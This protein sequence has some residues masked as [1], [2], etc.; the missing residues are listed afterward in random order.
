MSLSNCDGD[1]LVVVQRPS[2]RI[3]NR[4]PGQIPA[5]VRRHVHEKDLSLAEAFPSWPFQP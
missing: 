5:E 2:E 1:T 3:R 4:Q